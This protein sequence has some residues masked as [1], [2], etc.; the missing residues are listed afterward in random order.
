MIDL[1][2]PPPWDVIARNQRRRRA[3]LHAKVKGRR[4]KVRWIGE[5]R[6][7]AHWIDMAWKAV[8]G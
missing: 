7:T 5:N 2:N 4:V 8:W 3:R 1:V 6:S